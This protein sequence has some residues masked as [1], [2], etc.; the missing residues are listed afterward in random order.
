MKTLESWFAEYSES[1]RNRTNQQIH[2]ICVPLILWSVVGFFSLLRVPGLPGGVLASAAIPLCL[3]LLVFYA[4]LG[5]VPFLQMLVQLGASLTLSF[6]L[7]HATKHVWI[8]YAAVF[9]AAWIG[10]AVGHLFEGKKPSFFK[11]LQFLLIGPLW[12]LRRH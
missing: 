2:R 4:L 10:Q 5:F 7:E 1:H 3:G 11:D 9:V 12:I 6:E 8:V